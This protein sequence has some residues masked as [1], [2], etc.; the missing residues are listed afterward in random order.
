VYRNEAFR[1]AK[2]FGGPHHILYTKRHMKKTLPTKDEAKLLL[3]EHVTDPYQRFHALMVATAVAGYAREYQADEQLWWLTGYLHDIDYEQYPHAHPGPS[4]DWFRVWGYPD[5]LIH[6]IEAHADGF[7]GFTQKPETDL[8]RVLVACDEICGI[9]YAYQ[10]LNPIPF[11]EMK[12]SS[13]KKRLKEDKFAPGINR[14]HIYKAITNL[15][16]SLEE[17]IENLISSLSIIP[18]TS[19]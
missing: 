9:F 19:K 15:D 1:P 13:I 16:I 10:K 7:N 11:G 3:F 17:H 4:L 12:V 5:E 14:E 2:T 6:A 18:L 8:A